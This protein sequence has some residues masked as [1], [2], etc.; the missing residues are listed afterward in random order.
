MLEET[1]TE[2][3]IGFFVIFLSLVTFQLRGRGGPLGPPGYTYVLG[4]FVLEMKKLSATSEAQFNSSVG[5]GMA[6]KPFGTKAVDI[7]AFRE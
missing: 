2:E 5:A 1:E 6:S 3:T 4:S 7:F